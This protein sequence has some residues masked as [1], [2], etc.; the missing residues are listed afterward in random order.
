M[1]W[2]RSNSGRGCWLAFFALACQF[3]FTFG[4]VHIGNV[5]IASPAMTILAD[6][7]TGKTG[8]PHSPQPSAPSNFA[9]DF[10][11][12]CS[13][14]SLAQSLLLPTSPIVVPPSSFVQELQ[15]TV[16][17]TTPTTRDHFH[18]EARGPPH[19]G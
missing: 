4:H 5:S 7:T 12:V 17:G 2:F 10:C 18:F 11:A 19:Q 6:V 15:W 3:V 16:V 13:S 1:G 8:A 14:I 9:P